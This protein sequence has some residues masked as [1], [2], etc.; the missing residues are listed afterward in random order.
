M[1]LSV[2]EGPHLSF[3]GSPSSLGKPLV[4]PY[5][6]VWYHINLISAAGFGYRRSALM[7]QRCRA[8]HCCLRVHGLCVLCAY[9]VC[10]Y[11]VVWGVVG[12]CQVAPVVV[13]RLPER[14]L[15]FSRPLLWSFVPTQKTPS[16]ERMTNAL[17]PHPFL[18]DWS[19][20][21]RRGACM[22]FACIASAALPVVLSVS[23]LAP[24]HD[25]GAPTNRH[26]PHRV[27]CHAARPPSTHT[28]C[29]PLIVY[30]ASSR[31]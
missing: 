24:T 4:T 17:V 2:T 7:A 10:I 11:V 30:K 19:S 13:G 20:S 25:R 3:G 31:L 14:L 1:L 9:C 15:L 23:M 27:A 5:H 21:W 29:R 16:Y 22:A 28:T 8:F 6:M 18:A 26:A 12:V